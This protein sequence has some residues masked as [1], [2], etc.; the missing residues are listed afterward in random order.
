MRLK[1]VVRPDNS[2]QHCCRYCHYC[3]WEKEAMGHVCYCKEVIESTAPQE[4]NVYGVS[5]NGYVSE[6]IEECM[7]NYDRKKLFI[8]LIKQKCLEYKVSGSRT[9]MFLKAFEDVYEEYSLFM[10]DDVDEAVSRV[11]Q[12]RYENAMCEQGDRTYIELDNVEDFC[13]RYWC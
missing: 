1:R 8:D 5:E 6:V 9:Q 12:E 3:G 11:Y 10:R 2:W 7:Q 13:C 4:F